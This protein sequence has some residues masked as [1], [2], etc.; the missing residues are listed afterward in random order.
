M[1]A[2]VLVVSLVQPLVRWIE[3]VVLVEM[4]VELVLVL[5]MGVLLG[6]S[7]VEAWLEKVLVVV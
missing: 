5:E 6:I 7:F 2:Q 1:L 3:V 4:N